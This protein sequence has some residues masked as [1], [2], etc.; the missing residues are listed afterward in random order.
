MTRRKGPPAGLIRFVLGPDGAVC[1]DVRARLPG[2][3]AWVDGNA[4]SV[5]LAVKRRSFARAF[6][7]DCA[8]DADLAGQVEALLETDCLGA[9]ALANKAGQVVCG[10]AKV[11]AALAAG[12]VRGLLHAA[13]ARADGVRKLGAAARRG[14]G[15]ASLFPPVQIFSEDQLD[16]ALGRSHVIH[17]ALLTGGASEA[18]L[19]RATRLQRFRGV[20]GAEPG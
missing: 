16:L 3:G 10:T 2:R 14:G 6:K 8:T 5:R 9:L 20:L 1:P 17:A 18:F 7:R 13:E 4:E 19:T 15:E 12:Q 11:E